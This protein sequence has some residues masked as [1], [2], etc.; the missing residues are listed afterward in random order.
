MKSSLNYT[1]CV[2]A[3]T[4]VFCQTCENSTSG[5]YY[6]PIDEVAEYLGKEINEEAFYKICTTIRL[7][8]ELQVLDVNE[9]DDEYAWGEG[10]FNMNIG[11]NYVLYEE[12]MNSE[13]DEEE[14]DEEEE[15]LTDEYYEDQFGSEIAIRICRANN[16]PLSDI[17]EYGSDAY[18]IN[19]GINNL[20]DLYDINEDF[21]LPTGDE[22][23]I[24]D[25][26]VE[27][28]EEEE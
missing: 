24:R 15:E 4:Y 7:D 21:V 26:R 3:A 22:E 11:T 25:Y 16:I 5:S 14:D 10:E 18:W 23:L 9:N 28:L 12:K 20:Q 1:E 13:S 27:I 19:D 8:F 2:K 17:E 6:I